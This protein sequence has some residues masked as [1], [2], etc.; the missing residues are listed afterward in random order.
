[1]ARSKL[2]RKLAKKVRT[3]WTR[4]WA[5]LVAEK[6]VRTRR[7]PRRMYERTARQ[8]DSAIRRSLEH[9]KTRPRG[10]HDARK[11]EKMIETRPAREGIARR[12]GGW[13]RI[14]SKSERSKMARRL[15]PAGLKRVHRRMVRGLRRRG[16]A[17][18]VIDKTMGY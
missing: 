12:L 5:K 13:G 17:R 16:S 1:M 10:W 4:K 14:I 3:N 7:L 11:I 15:G 8:G 6:A 9:G 18:D 2:V